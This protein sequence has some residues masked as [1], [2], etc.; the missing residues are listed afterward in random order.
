MSGLVDLFRLVIGVD[1]RSPPDRVIEASVFD[2]VTVK[3]VQ[4]PTAPPCSTDVT[5]MVP[6]CPLLVSPVA[7][8]KISAPLG[9][10]RSWMPENGATPG[11]KL[12]NIRPDTVGELILMHNANVISSV[13]MMPVFAPCAESAIVFIPKVVNS[14]SVTRSRALPL[15]SY[16]SCML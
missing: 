11:E 2:T 16:L 12:E 4:P 5:E 14:L 3:R 1:L 10:I 8:C 15:E 7:I 13:S 6:V 9:S